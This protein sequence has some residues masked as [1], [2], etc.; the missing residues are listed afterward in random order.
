MSGR[1]RQSMNM[2]DWLMLI[3]LSIL[4]GGSFF[5]VGVAVKALTP[6]TIVFI[7]LSLAALTLWVIV[8]LMKVSP[9]ATLKAWQALTV[10]GILNNVIPFSL[11]V[12]GQSHIESGLASIFNAMTPLFTV[13]VAGI[14]LSDERISGSKLVG[15]FLGIGGAAVMVGTDVLSGLSTDVLAQLAVM[16]AA[17]SYGFSTVWGRRFKTLGLNP[18]AIAAGQVSM[19]AM[20]LAPLVFVIEKPLSQPLPGLHVWAALLALAV[21]STALAY[22]LFFKVLASA[23]ATNV[24]L[25]TFL[26]PISAIVLG[27]IFL[28]ERLTITHFIGMALIALGLSAIDG[29]LWRRR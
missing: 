24:S 23:G 16:G 29:R 9:P 26:V 11:I 1:I 19:S 6:L 5:F 3:A 4:W 12:W 7:R 25:V 10:M 2:Q 27:F 18:I 8:A 13:L 20:L 21:F 17:V 14:F 28:N 22:I 15:V